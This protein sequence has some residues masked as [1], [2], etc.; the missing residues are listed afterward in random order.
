MII[1]L[2]KNLK[3]NQQN[4]YCLDITALLI[5][6]PVHKMAAFDLRFKYEVFR[7]IELTLY[8]EQQPIGEI[9]LFILQ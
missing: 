2:N 5:L 9:K 4:V 8:K 3:M 7:Q 1:K 6:R